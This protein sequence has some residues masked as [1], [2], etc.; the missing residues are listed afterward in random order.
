TAGRR[1][2][3]IGA[4]LLASL[5]AALGLAPFF[6]AAWIVGE[7]ETL[8][9]GH[10]PA[11]AVALIA[12][13]VTAPLAHGLA[14][15]LA[16]DGAFDVLAELRERL[17]AKMLRL[18]LDTLTRVPAGSMK[19]MMTDDV[20]TLELFLS[21]QLPDMVA[22]ISVP[23]LTVIALMVIDWRLALACL[24]VV[25]FLVW[26][27]RRTLQGHGQRI[28][29]YFRKIGE[30]NAAAVEFVRGI[31]EIRH[32]RSGGLVAEV[33]RRRVEDFKAFAQEWYRLWG[34][35]WSLYCVLVG[36]AP[37]AVI[38]LVLVF[39]TQGDMSFPVLVVGLFVATGIGG[40]LAKLP[41]YGEITHQVNG[42]EKRIR[43]MLARPEVS[44]GSGGMLAG[45]A[46]IGEAAR[47]FGVSL[48]LG[49]SEVL[50]DVSFSVPQGR[51]TAIVGPSGAGKSSILR[52]LNRSWDPT[53]GRIHLGGIDLSSLAVDQLSRHVA[54]VSQEAFLFDDTVAANIRA[55]RPEATDEEVRA[56]AGQA[57]CA[58]FIEKA[59][60]ESYETR[61]GEGG[62]RLSGG[63]RQRLALARALLAGSPL[64]LLD[65]ATSFLDARHEADLQK[66]IQAIIGPKT[67]VVV[68]HRLDSTRQADHI[69]FVQAGRVMGEGGHE[70]LLDRC[71]DYARLWD[72]QRRNLE[73]RFSTGENNR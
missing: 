57:L 37:L 30:V 65:E 24:A 6:L 69:V 23:T 68:S 50:E 3:F 26:V 1:G 11:L 2:R 14:T 9:A 29:V 39:Y 19:R 63:Q 51:L 22:C 49:E 18:P 28:G 66:A 56:A 34:P 46:P 45:S 21:H 70:R 33:L 31:E 44:G 40:P 5:G 38:P 72:L 54:L 53:A 73:W 55:G 61:L 15:A 48:S 36:A 71:P 47:F 8:S 60:P 4:C 12:S 52:L 17:V 35:P 10:T 27:Q 16:H 62:Q 25:P 41:I 32:A 59:L 43:D 7:G 64:L 20:E 58:S 13:L 42:A 67:V